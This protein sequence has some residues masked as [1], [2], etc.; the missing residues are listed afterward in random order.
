[1]PAVP[2]QPPATPSAR[3]GNSLLV[4][5]V[6]AVEPLTGRRI[7]RTCLEM[8]LAAIVATVVSLP[9][10]FVID[11]LHIPRPSYV[12]VAMTSLAAVALVGG[13]LWLVTR[14]RFAVRSIV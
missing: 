12:T 7:W 11:R 2:A 5:P 14:S 6:C 10:Q 13:A 8:L 1:K 3:Y 9:M 4:D